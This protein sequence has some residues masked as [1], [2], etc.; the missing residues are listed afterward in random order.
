MNL[1]QLDHVIA[2]ADHQNFHRAADA[3]GLTQPALTQSIRKLEEELGVILFE[4]AKRE[5]TPTAF[6]IATIQSARVAV[7]HI[8]NLRR[9][10][11]LMRNLQSG[12]LIIGCDPWIAEGL[13]APALSRI[14]ELYPRLTFSVKVGTFDTMMQDLLSGATDIYVG[15]PPEARDERIRWIDI[16]LPPIKLMCRPGH[17]LL[18]L[19]HPTPADCLAYPIAAPFMPR[20][21]QDW[22][23]TQIGNPITADGR[24]IYSSF[25]KSDDLGLMRR[26][27][28]SSETI[29]SMFP[30]MVADDLARGEL[31]IVPLREMNFSLP[32]IICH[33]GTQPI[34]PA[35]ELLVRELLA[36]VETLAAD[37]RS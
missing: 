33:R 20:W 36:E 32:A 34:S 29:A 5:V 14:L 19:E 2:L 3:V 26:L 1:R 30:A 8:A 4:R 12:R 22:I 15:A 13:L 37:D 6:G 16:A 28:K 35:G 11:D 27:V 17:P 25:L 23:G 7:A 9:E 21:Y 10:L 31:L 24:D 18:R